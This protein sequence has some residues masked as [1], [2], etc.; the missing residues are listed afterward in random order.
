MRDIKIIL[1]ITLLNE[2]KAE[3]RKFHWIDACIIISVVIYSFLEVYLNLP[4]QVKIIVYSLFCAYMLC[5][6]VRSAF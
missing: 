2:R 3:M 5:R 6:I 1:D 4:A